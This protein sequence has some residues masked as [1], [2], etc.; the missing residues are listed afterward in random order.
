VVAVTAVVVDPEPPPGLVWASD[1]EPGIRRRGRRRFR[2]VDERTGE[3]VCD[4]EVLDRIRRLAVPP[5]WTDV[6]ICTDA[7]GHLQAVGRDVRGRKQYRYHG[8]FRAVREDAKF[9]ELATFGHHLDGLRRQV[10]KD[11]AAPGL[12]FEKVTALVVSLLDRTLVRVGNEEYARTNDSYGLTTL[13]DH[14]ASVTGRQVRLSFRGKS[15]RDHDIALGDP[16]LARLV[17][18]CQELPGQTLFQYVD[19]CGVRPLRSTDVNAYL[20]AVTGQPVTAKTFRTWAATVLAAAALVEARSDDERVRAAAV[21]AAAEAVARQLGNTPAVCRRSYIHPDVVQL[22]LDDRLAG[23]WEVGPSRASS[24]LLREERRL[25][26]VLDRL[27]GGS[28][29]VA[30]G[31]GRS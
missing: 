16:R 31:T 8:D 3:Q 27:N 7:T 14:H 28:R 1:A 19:E 30:R 29:P 6:W 17:R 21:R 24:R 11:L 25:L 2:Y 4:V 26:H 22:H 12:A 9:G 18:R 15:G 23:L 13:R 10:S 20:S 5:A